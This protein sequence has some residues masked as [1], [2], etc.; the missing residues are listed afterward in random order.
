[1]IVAFLPRI[2]DQIPDRAAASRKK[3]KRW[4]R[5]NPRLWFAAE[6]K[7]VWGDHRVRMAPN[8]FEYEFGHETYRTGL[9][10]KPLPPASIEVTRAPDN[11]DPFARSQYIAK[12]PFFDSM[13]RRYAQGSILTGQ[14]VQVVSGEQQGLVG[15]MVDITNDVADVVQR[16]DDDTPPLQLQVPLTEL[17]PLYK[18]GDHVKYMWSDSH[19][20]VTSSDLGLVTFVD[21]RTK[22]EVRTYVT[23]IMVANQT[24]QF[25]SSVCFVVLHTP[26][27]NFYQ[28]KP[29]TWVDFRG[30]KDT[31]RAKRRGWVHSVEDTHALVIDER[32]Y[33][34]V[35]EQTNS[36]T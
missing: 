10:V 12:L 9:L 23:D 29:G 20:I 34:E 11:I 24:L 1:M 35:S 15:Y 13:A 16:V 21:M 4:V 3:R 27:L 18:P 32:T 19:G 36:K 5:P 22:E 33:T 28:F 26:S 7:A 14:W 17:L 2:S 25:I 30:P 8:A 6:V 31:E